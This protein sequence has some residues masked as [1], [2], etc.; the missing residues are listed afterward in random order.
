MKKKNWVPWILL[1]LIIITVAL[2]FVVR[3]E[4]K[5]MDALQGNGVEKQEE[6]ITFCMPETFY[7]L[8]GQ[9]LEIYNHQVTEL[10]DGITSY[11]VLWECEIGENLERK[12]SLK[13]EGGME[14]EYPLTLFI[15]DNGLTLLAEKKCTLKLI[16]GDTEKVKELT[17][18]FVVGDYSLSGYPDIDPA[19]LECC[20]DME[21]VQETGKQQ[22]ADVFAAIVCG[23]F[24][25]TSTDKEDAL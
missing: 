2:L 15:Y 3:T 16:K 25:E 10:G 12:Y 4:R 7:V 9:M 22:S 13:A 14:G 1:L 19:Q 17:E 24:D 21:N 18:K 11:N 23:T 8:E 6:E 5:K 20:V